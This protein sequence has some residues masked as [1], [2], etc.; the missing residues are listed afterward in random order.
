VFIEL[1]DGEEPISA[2]YTYEGDYH[3]IKAVVLEDDAVYNEKL[4]NIVRDLVDEDE[5]WFDHH[6]GCQAHGYL[7]LRP[8]EKCPH[9]KGRELLEKA[10]K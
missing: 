4:L 7:S 8:G 6:G 5:C 2:T 3:E 1:D 10:K 9:Q